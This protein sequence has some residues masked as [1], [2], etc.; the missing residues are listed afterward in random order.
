MEDVQL[1]HEGNIDVAAPAM[2]PVQE[3]EEWLTA[4]RATGPP[5]DEAVAALCE[6]LVRGA[7]SEISRRWADLGSKRSRA[8]S[9][10]A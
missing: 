2:W 3:R 6:L 4:L 8:A 1:Q 9:T 10:W 5:H 7:R